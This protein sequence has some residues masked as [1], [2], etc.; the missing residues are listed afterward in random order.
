MP[1]SSGFWMRS[2]IDTVVSLDQQYRP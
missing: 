2:H 1:I